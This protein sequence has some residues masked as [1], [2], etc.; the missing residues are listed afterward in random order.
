MGG[1]GGDDAAGNATDCGGGGHA[2]I[3]WAGGVE[4][5]WLTSMLFGCLVRASTLTG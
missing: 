3:L 2:S 1:D 5:V 4:S